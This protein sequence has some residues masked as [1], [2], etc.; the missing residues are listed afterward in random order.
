M[1]IEEQLKTKTKQLEDIG[2]EINQAQR[3]ITEN[4]E[5]IN[6]KTSQALKLDGAISVCKELQE[7]K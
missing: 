1:N 4:R 2:R 7:N 3:V 5:V 6:Q